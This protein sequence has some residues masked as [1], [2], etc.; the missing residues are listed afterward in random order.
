MAEHDH[1][2]ETAESAPTA[3][4]SDQELDD[5]CGRCATVEGALDGVART[6]W[7]EVEITPQISQIGCVIDLARAE[8]ARIGEEIERIAKARSAC[9]E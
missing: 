7:S 1:N 5:L 9:P 3:T 6:I 2:V 4:Y 8:L